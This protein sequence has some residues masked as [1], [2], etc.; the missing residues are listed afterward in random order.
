[1]ISATPTGKVVLKPKRALPFYARHPW[2]FAGATERVEGTPADGDVVDLVSSTGNFV[3]RGLFNS[4]SKIRVRLYSWDEAVPLDRAFFKERIARAIA[5]RHDVL[6]LNHGSAAAYRVVFSEADVLSGMVVD[7]YGDYL[8]V[9]FTSLAIGM[10]REMIAEILTEL[11]NPKGIYLRTEKGIGQLEGL[12]L[13]DGLLAGETPPAEIMIEEN[14]L[15]FAVNLA[16]GQK[17]GY[18]LDQRDNRAVVGRLATGR[19]VLDAFCYSGGFGVYAAKAGASE[20]ESVDASEAAL[21]LA[22]RNAVVNGLSQIT[23]T[24]A[25]VFNYL[26]KMA[27]EGRTFDLVVLDPPKFARNRAAIPQALQGYRKLHQHAMKL[28]AKDGILASCCCTGL[29]TSEMLEDLISQVAV[30]ARRDL[31]ILERR[32]P[33]ADHPV[34]AACRES[35]YLKCIISRVW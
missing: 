30:D 19:R 14:G 34:A 27:T 33:A 7:R 18:Y 26:G 8:T 15:K 3:A 13:H 22:D 24:Q 16:E 23:L 10:R 11:L 21:R 12:E 17:T 31:Q 6:H 29:I 9:Q 28:L 4:Q 5:L 35:G 32:G 1:M 20:V 25:D 2:V